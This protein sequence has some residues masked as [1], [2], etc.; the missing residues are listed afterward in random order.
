[1]VDALRVSPSLSSSSKEVRVKVKLSRN[2]GALGREAE[3]LKRLGGC[4]S[5]IGVL[6]FL[7]NYDRRGGHA[8]VLEAGEEDLVGLVQRGGAQGR[9]EIKRWV[10]GGMKKRGGAG[11][12]GIRSSRRRRRRR[13]RSVLIIRI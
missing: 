7:E 3:N 1:V 9:G 2:L 6:D 10:D 11:G 13:R 5:V 12:G 4:R 8:L